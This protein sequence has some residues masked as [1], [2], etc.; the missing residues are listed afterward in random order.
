[1]ASSLVTE[2]FVSVLSHP[3]GTDAPA[4]LSKEPSEPVE[5]DF[6]LVP[7]QIR[8]FLTHYS[9]LLIK[10]HAFN[11]CSACSKPILKAYQENGI[12]FLLSVINES[13]IL[14]IVSG[15]RAMFE[16]TKAIDVEWDDE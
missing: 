1:M 14:E 8:G 15:L 6:G 5:Y 7:H 16:E 11:K 9:N 12:E 13:G 4:D 2:L 3:L 10:G